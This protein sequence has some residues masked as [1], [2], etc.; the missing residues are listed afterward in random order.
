MRALVG[1]EKRLRVLL[2]A[3]TDVRWWY[4]RLS[5]HGFKST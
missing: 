2:S 5:T 1:S 3:K 4:C